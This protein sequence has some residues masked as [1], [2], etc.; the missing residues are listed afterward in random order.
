M[1]LYI[2]RKHEF[3]RTFSVRWF[4]TKIAYLYLE[5]QYTESA[6]EAKGREKADSAVLNNWEPLPNHSVELGDSRKALHT[7]FH[8]T[9]PSM[10]PS[11][12]VTGR[13]E[14]PRSNIILAAFSIW[15]DF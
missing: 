10:V 14:T 1:Y 6:I 15:Q 11:G 4:E 13:Q 2:V 7:S 9:T 8:V 3:A 5:V 12:I